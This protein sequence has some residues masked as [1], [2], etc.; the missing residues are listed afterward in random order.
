MARVFVGILLPENL[1]N[2]VVNAQKSLENLPI[3]CKFVEEQNLHVSL[4]FIGEV[5]GDGQEEIK[6][7]ISELA[8]KENTFQAEIGDLKLIPNENFVRVIASEI[9]SPELFNIGK[10]LSVAIGGDA[11]P[12]HLTLCRVKKVLSK[13]ELIEKFELIKHVEIGSFKVSSIQLIKS[14]LRTDGPVYSVVS[15]FSF[16]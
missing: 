6:E 5:D 13:R 12:P 10:K 3:K 9:N 16:G 1:K 8:K 4:D 15:D 14:E 11:K 2:L 7:K